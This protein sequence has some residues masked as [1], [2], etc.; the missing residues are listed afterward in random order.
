MSTY[1]A[2][3]IGISDVHVALLFLS[4]V[5]DSKASMNACLMTI[6]ICWNLFDINSFDNGIRT[7]EF[8]VPPFD[9]GCL[10]YLRDLDPNR[11][12]LDRYISLLITFQSVSTDGKV[13]SMTIDCKGECPYI[14]ERR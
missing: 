1:R 8:S 5:C 6:Y 11:V 9:A 3:D 2:G 4:S 13:W 14:E 10:I 7:G 12:C